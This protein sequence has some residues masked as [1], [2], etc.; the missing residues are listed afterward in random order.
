MCIRD[1]VK[2]DLRKDRSC[3]V[4]DLGKLGG[5]F[6]EVDSDTG[7]GDVFVQLRR[8]KYLKQEEEQLFFFL[9]VALKTLAVEA[10]HQ[11]PD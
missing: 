2:K 6:F 9:Q 3:F 7:A 8:P 10:V 11:V 5:L 4:L 1:R